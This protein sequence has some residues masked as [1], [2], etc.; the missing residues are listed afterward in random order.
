MYEPPVHKMQSQKTLYKIGSGPSSSHTM[1]PKKAAE[2]F[3]S[4]HP[5]AKKIEVELFGS[6]AT[7][8]KGH[9]TD[10][11][12]IKA[13]DGIEC[14]IIWNKKQR[15]RYHTNGIRFQELNDKNEP[16][17]DPE[18]YYSIGGG[19]IIKGKKED[20]DKKYPTETIFQDDAA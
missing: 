3:R 1:G 5:D 4:G 8:G 7:T 10:T 11:A 19:I 15:L 12:I 17:G 13:L 16:L 6:L 2:E 14:D 20:L 18:V 9:K